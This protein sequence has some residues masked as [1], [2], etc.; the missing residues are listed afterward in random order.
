MDGFTWFL[1]LVSL[2]EHAEKAHV[3]N[4]FPPEAVVKENWETAQKLTLKI[5]DLKNEWT[6]H[7]LCNPEIGRNLEPYL[8]DAQKT[9]AFWFSAWWVVWP[10]A[11]ACDRRAHYLRCRALI[12]TDA[13]DSLEWPEPIPW[14]ARQQR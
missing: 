13:F 5:Q 6:G 1:L 9:E 10:N 11:S 12:G 3:C 7:G 2:P 14:W 8:Q 4:H